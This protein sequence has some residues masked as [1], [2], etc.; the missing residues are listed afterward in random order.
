MATDCQRFA[1][2]I[3]HRFQGQRNYF[4]L[5]V[6]QGF[7]LAD[8]RKA[9]RLEDVIVHTKAY[10]DSNWASISA[11]QLVGALLRADEVLPW[12]TTRENFE[13]TM[14]SYLSN[15][16]SYAGH[17]EIDEIKQHVLGSA[18]ILEL[19]RVRFLSGPMTIAYMQHRELIRTRKSGSSWHSL[20]IST[21][22]PYFMTLY[23]RSGSHTRRIRCGRRLTSISRGYMSLIRNSILI[24]L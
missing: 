6:E 17:V 8:G 22:Q 21:L 5:C 2:E 7:Q 12:Q 9:L 3:A 1:E 14:K 24:G 4:R 10:L 11:D 13:E 18:G 20:W 16:Q 15:A 19:I 23:L